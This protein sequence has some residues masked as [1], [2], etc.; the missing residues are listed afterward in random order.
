MWQP[1]RSAWRAVRRS[2][3]SSLVAVL[4]LAAGIGANAVVFSALE[5]ALLTP[6][7]VAD[8][9]RV[10]SLTE[11]E[12][13]RPD[14]PSGVSFPA[15]AEWQA[16]LAGQADLAAYVPG[17]YAISGA[18]APARVGAALV[19]ASFFDVTGVRPVLGRVFG[20]D[21]DRAGAAPAV[22]ASH[23]FWREHL[24]ADPGRV[25]TTFTFGGHPATLVG[26]L[27]S[28]FDLIE[29]AALYVPL[30]VF[31][32]EGWVSQR[33]VHVLSVIA[34]LRP[35]ADTGAVARRIDALQRGAEGEDP[36]HVALAMTLQQARSGDLL[37]PLTLLQA[38]AGLLLAIACINL[39]GVLAA[40]VQSREREWAVR[41]ALGASA[42]QIVGLALG[43]S[44]LLAGLGAL[45]GLAVAA[46]AAPLLAYLVPD[47]RLAGLRVDPRVLLFG[48]AAA[49]LSGIAAGTLPTRAALRAGRTGLLAAG[50]AR[51][52][53]GR[54]AR[55]L[56]SVLVAGQV[57]A[58]LVLLVGGALL[59]GSLR[60]ALG[61][62]PGFRSDSLLTLRV[63]PPPERY[64]A[65]A[66][67]VR[68]FATAA[69]ELR[70]LPS[71]AAVGAVSV[72]PVSGPGSKGEVTVEGP[73]LPGDD[74]PAAG[75][76][77][78]LPGY[79]EA[80]GVPIVAGRD[81]DA[82]D[83]GR[84]ERVTIVTAGLARRLWPGQDP[85]GR[86]IKVG[87]AESEPW[88]RVV[89]VAG[90]IAQSALDTP[91]EYQ[92]FEPLAQRP[93][94]MLRFAV[95][96]TGSPEALAG[97]VTT[98]LRGLE[99]QVVV[100]QVATMD[101]RIGDSLR[102]RRLQATLVAL[103][104]ALAAA[105]A[106]LGVYGIASWCVTQRRREIGVRAALGAAPRDILRF[107]LAQALGPAGAGLLAGIVLAAGSAS[108][109]RG[110]LFGVAPLDAASHLASLL[111][112]AAV[113]VASSVAPALRALSVSPAEVLRQE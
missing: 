44:L 83:D 74:K 57:A 29:D 94:G 26:V 31:R 61:V 17:E 70:R 46:W 110:L 72:L 92:T 107:A 82:R 63:A 50:D 77:R 105:I 90:E 3:G 5:V 106:A 64:D 54:R 52:T 10:L 56:Q 25:G 1:I 43:E 68:F 49:V 109:L 60:R 18:G 95:R 24:G 11:A 81:F 41:R 108:L 85:I 36:G 91:P 19:S 53:A 47:T 80:L 33:R 35:G 55:R 7:P 113:V 98:A 13:A 9:A 23:A 21:E 89:G 42:G 86:R 104:A 51:Q 100:D 84:G 102:P 20:A 2:P 27:P 14:R 78:V 15:Y 34:R 28:R 101:A 88:L 38:A 69:G 37:L 79:F 97:A 111:A 8:P 16:G 58:A 96:T 59:L 73:A 30:G 62:S 67:V 22:V 93:R 48:A 71:V 6:P 65:P 76:L 66:D 99:P 39:A 75:F 12:R 32:S 112:L 103:F 4:T 40:R 45:A 87:P